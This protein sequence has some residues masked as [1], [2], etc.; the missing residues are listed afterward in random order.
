MSAA[1]ESPLSELRL[2]PAREVVSALHIGYDTLNRAL[3]TGALVGVR[4]PGKKVRFTEGAVRAWLRSC[5]TEPTDWR[6]K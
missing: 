6:V 4:M 2:Y 5:E 1:G 3:A